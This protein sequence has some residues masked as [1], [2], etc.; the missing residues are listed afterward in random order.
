MTDYVNDWENPAVFRRNRWRMHTPVGAYENAEQALSCDRNRSR[1]TSC[2]DGVWK[3]RMYGCPEEVP[4]EVFGVSYDDGDWAKIAVPGCWELNGYGRPVYTNVDY[5]FQRTEGASHHE[6]LLGFGRYELD[7]PR[8]PKD[9]PTGCYRMEFT[10]GDFHA[11]REVFLDFEGVESCFYL[12]VNGQCVGYSQDSKLNAVF[13]V[14]EY[15]HPGQ[16]LLAIEV[17]KYSDGSYL[18]DQDYWHLY[19][20]T[21]SVRM[22]S[23][24]QNRIEDFM[25]QTLFPQGK[26]G[27]YRD[28]V[29]EVTVWPNNRIAAYG[30]N[31]VEVE[32][33][34]ADG[35]M[36]ASGGSAPIAQ[37]GCYLGNNFVAKVRVPVTAPLL[38]T[39]E[40]P[41][42]Y[43]V[44]I[45]LVGPAGELLDVESGRVGFRE[46]RISG[47]GVLLLNGKRLVIRG[48]NRHEFSPETGRYVSEEHMRREIAAM[49]RLNFNAVRTSHY[50]C[51]TRWYDLCDELGIYLVDETNLETH[52]IGGQ[53]SASPEW[54]AAY[55]E[56][57]SRMVLRD[58]NHP[59]VLIWS[60][61]NESG[62][63][64]NHAAMYGWIREYDK[65]RPVQ[66]E[67]ANPGPNISDILCPMYPP[68]NWV[69]AC[70]AN[71]SDLRPF[72]TCE[73]A[74]AKSNSNGNFRIFWDAIRKYPRYQ[75]G[76]I[77][78]FADKAILKDGRF[79]YG[80]AFGEAVVD[81]TPDMCLNGVLFPDLTPKPGTDEVKNI[82][83]PVQ[84]TFYTRYEPDAAAGNGMRTFGKIKNE[85]HS[86][87][88]ENYRLK[89]E[90]V[91]NGKAVYEGCCPLAAEAGE[92][93]EL[94]LESIVKTLSEAGIMSEGARLSLNLSVVLAED[95]FYAPKGYEICHKQV[96]LVRYAAS[97]EELAAEA[98]GAWAG[99][100]AEVFGDAVSVEES[101]A[102]I[103]ISS[104]GMALVFNKRTAVFDSVRN[105]GR[106]LFSGGA[107]QFYR[108][109]TGID[110]GTHEP[111]NCY[112]YEWK[113]AG[114]DQA[115]YEVCSLNMSQGEDHVLI[116]AS[117]C[118]PA[119]DIR[120]E[121][122]WT[123][124]SRGIR[125]SG[126]VRNNCAAETLP[127]I[128]FVFRLTERF[129]H[130]TWYGRG[131]LET[132]ADRKDTACTGT[133]R[134]SV[135][136]QH[137]PYIVPCECGGHED[138]EFASLSES[139]GGVCLIVT[140]TE[141]FHFSA[142]PY[143]TA[144]YAK[145]AYQDELVPDGF[146]YLNLDVCH[147][148]L[149]GDT[150]WTKT[151]HPEY[152]IGNGR[153]G[154][155]FTIAWR[156]V[157]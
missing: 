131:P 99:D 66:Y 30:E 79:C 48:V 57:A 117:L 148:G 15:L 71:A 151:I 19:G 55:V 3:F 28:A 93:E 64:A 2:L 21:R 31:H 120:A 77:W 138:T 133:Y 68:M 154:F 50:P 111:G 107:F 87:S 9:N 85:F 82:Q 132:Y 113:K 147:A 38:W 74:Y 123:L 59:S 156:E 130:V 52:G 20:I 134:S 78:D 41:D 73:Y 112:D 40:T 49:K 51:S 136:G 61:G 35:T 7:V 137:V 122:E 42:L 45:K 116:R 109:P 89:W 101:D 114:L 149:G 47:E 150:G 86:S 155:D 125:F 5:P 13:H 94:P 62:A 83:S 124:G 44:L 22:Y 25:T 145:A 23:R 135:A 54:T 58:K 143:S 75:G 60:L 90:A 4:E 144:A 152:Q 76:F 97:P 37:C 26:D 27:N 69:E 65:S 53:L 12:W 146:H 121:I 88:L 6:I 8:V 70:M 141:P 10:V 81:G 129:D 36:I 56:R 139:A 84:I 24:P 127:R 95:T 46:V 140:G 16:N 153:Y 157:S 39:A 119:A 11:G 18:E 108:A 29:L 80:G 118:W 92:D 110:E 43:T 34:R 128:G 91:K 17:I 33:Y 106:E 142:L 67:S 104:G 98:L 14:T 32:L 103:R 115:K 63:G 96:P 102:C 126:S 100:A 1:Y 105:Q 72:I